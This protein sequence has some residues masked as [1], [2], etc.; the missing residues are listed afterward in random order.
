MAGLNRAVL[1]RINVQMSIRYLSSVRKHMRCVDGAEI[2]SSA[3]NI[4]DFE[5][6]WI[7][8]RELV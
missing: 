1:R 4:L 2:R 7:R 3:H 5:R 6:D 8:P